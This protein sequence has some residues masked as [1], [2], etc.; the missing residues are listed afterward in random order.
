MASG[1]CAAAL[2]PTAGRAQLVRDELANTYVRLDRNALT[3][4]RP[5]PD[6]AGMDAMKAAFR[7]L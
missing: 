2:R 6:E 5:Q 7:A 4:G 3:D 1:A